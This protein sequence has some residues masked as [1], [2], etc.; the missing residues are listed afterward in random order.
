MTKRPVEPEYSVVVPVY[1]SDSSLRELVVRLRAVFDEVTVAGWEIIL[2]DDGSPS[3]TTWSTCVELSNEFPQVVAIRLMRNYGKPGAILCGLEHVRGKWTITIDDDL[4]QRPEDIAKL[5][6][7]RHHDVV[8]ANFRTRRQGLVARIGSRVKGLFDRW[9]LN[10][11][12]RMSP[13]KLFNAEVVA[14][15]LRVRTVHPFIPALMAHV[16]TD[17]HEVIVPHEDRPRVRSRYTLRRRVSQFSNLLLG[18]SSLVL[19][20]LGALGT[21]VAVSGFVFALSV[22]IRKLAGRIV[23]S[24]WASLVVINLVFGGLMLIGLGI[25][26][27]Y[28][29]RILHGIS[30]RPPYLVRE[31]VAEAG[32]RQEH[33]QAGPEATAHFGSSRPSR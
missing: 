23:E 7:H 28:L 17:F 9:I 14:G 31:I 26:G 20:G 12:C 33:H 25:V 18:N 13:L 11:P 10:L 6:P 24:G 30:D 32:V 2:V 21:A 27:E 15:M 1:Q 4:Q 16:T 5:V 3:A 22:V 29:I 19:R 8:V